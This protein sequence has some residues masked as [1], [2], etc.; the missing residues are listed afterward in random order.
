MRSAATVSRIGAP[1][2]R[3]AVFIVIPR[4]V[5]RLFGTFQF[6][7]E[8]ANDPILDHLATFG[9]DRMSDIG[10]QLGAALIVNIQFV[11]VLSFAT[12]VAKPGS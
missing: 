3:L 1:I 5:S 10:V 4:D 6:F 8:F 12:V 11:V 7:V 9:V 2:A